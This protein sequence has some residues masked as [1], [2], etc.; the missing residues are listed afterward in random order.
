M[1]DLARAMIFLAVLLRAIAKLTAAGLVVMT[2]FLLLDVI[3]KRVRILAELKGLQRFAEV[4]S[5]HSLLSHG[6]YCS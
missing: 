1:K 4:K 6:K 2:A 3:T 5:L